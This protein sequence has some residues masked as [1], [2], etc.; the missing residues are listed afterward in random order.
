MK[1]LIGLL[2]VLAV[3]GGV[4]YW[5]AIDADAPAH[6]Q[7]EINL[8]AYRALV[9][10]DAPQSLPGAIRVEFV[11][12]S[13]APGFAA[14]AGAFN[15]GQRTFS[16]NSFAIVT[17]EGDIIVDGAVD[18]A[19]LN[20]MSD[21]KGG[22]DAAAYRSVLTAMESA[23][24]I[25]ITHEHLDHVMAVARHPSPA[26]IAPRLRLT[27]AQ[28]DGLPQ[29]APNGVL[30]PA[31]ASVAPLDLSTPQRIAPGVVAAAAPGHAPGEIVIYVRTT[32]HEYLLIGDI[33]W[34]Y[35]SIRHARGRPRFIRW[36][37]PAV[38]PDRPRV[39]RQLRELHDISV[40]EPNLV[41]LPAHDD[42]YLR[43]LVARDVLIA[44]FNTA[45]PAPT[46]N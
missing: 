22:F 25:M 27:R 46:P 33:A 34:V 39:L 11:A 45:A 35:D 21:N 17:P 23:R 31:I 44:G 41:I 5:A 3:L 38:D 26:L 43:G 15:A 24:A 40:A 29:H 13:L 6:S 2:A 19:T 9:A 10:N 20:Q 4:F 42:A 28:L 1:W 16:Y 12:H 8:A 37:M 36:I 18:R 32:G 30:A 7:G 14:E